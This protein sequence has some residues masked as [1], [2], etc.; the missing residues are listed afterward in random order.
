[1]DMSK[2]NP[3]KVIIVWDTLRDTLTLRVQQADAYGEKTVHLSNVDIN[4][5]S[6]N[7][8]NISALLKDVDTHG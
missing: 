2:V 5:I 3:D 6:T 4:V 1:M 8:D 7:I